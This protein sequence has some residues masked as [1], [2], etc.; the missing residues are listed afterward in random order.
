M[1]RASARGSE[2]HTVDSGEV[3]IRWD[4]P[5]ATVFLNGVE[6]SAIHTD[7]PSILE[8]EYMQHAT[9]ALDALF[10]VTQRIRALHLGGAACALPLAWATLR[11]GSRQSA[12]EIDADLAGAVREWFD[13]PR[14][15]ALSIRVG[16]ARAVM[17]SMKDASFD[18]I[19]RDTFDEGKVPA[20]LRT[21]GF[22]RE[23]KRVLKSKGLF[24]LNCAHG[25][26]EDARREIAS[27]REEFSQLCSIQDPK[28]GRSGRRGNVLVVASSCEYP[29]DELDRR[30]RKL[31]LPARVTHG[32]ALE[33]WCASARPFLDPE[34]SS[35]DADLSQSAGSAQSEGVVSKAR[36]VVLPDGPL[37]DW[38]EFVEFPQKNQ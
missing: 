21:T 4:G 8:F 28:V 22:A 26:G 3:E 34:S 31:P 33:Q 20:H 15:P 17:C 13:L 7:D 10:P 12:V 19:V 30:L 5:V 32:R 25:G 27:L 23:A 1:A 37:Q 14:S 9:C 36:V 16:D 6:S 18:V 24:L 38:A 2:F 35:Q 11:P 29:I